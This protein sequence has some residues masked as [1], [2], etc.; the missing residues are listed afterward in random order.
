MVSKAFETGVK[1]SNQCSVNTD[2]VMLVKI[3][4]ALDTPRNSSANGLTY[5]YAEL[6]L[7][8]W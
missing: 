6:K 2:R 5:F 4:T 7:R 8:K 3:S 1:C